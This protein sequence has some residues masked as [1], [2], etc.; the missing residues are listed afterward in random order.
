MTGGRTGTTGFMG[1][2]RLISVDGNYKLPTDWKED[3]FCCKESVVFDSC[4]MV[5]RCNP[6]PCQ[7]GGS[8]R[9]SS[10]EFFCDCADTG[11]SGAVC[12][13]CKFIRL[14]SLY[15]VCFLDGKNV[16]CDISHKLTFD[17]N[18]LMI[19]FDVLNNIK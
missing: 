2:M 17:S 3:E 4:Q 14:I 5:D 12:H 6:N 7:H 16:T 10:K 8:C 11:Y 1:C 15:A 19:Q 13:T 18:F 9:Q